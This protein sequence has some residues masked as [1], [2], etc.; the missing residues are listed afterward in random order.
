MGERT[1]RRM[2]AEDRGGNIEGETNMKDNS[3]GRKGHSREEDNTEDCGGT[4]RTQW[5]GEQYRR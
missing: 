2:T 1:I 4:R 3:R 5:R